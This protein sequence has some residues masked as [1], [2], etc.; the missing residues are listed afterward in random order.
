VGKCQKSQSFNFGENTRGENCAGAVEGQDR[1]EQQQKTTTPAK[2]GALV[3]E[4]VQ[5]TAQG[6]VNFWITPEMLF[7]DEETTQRP[8]KEIEML[9]LAFPK[10]PTKALYKLQ[11]SIAQEI[12]SRA[13]SDTTNLQLAQE[14]NTSLKEALSQEGKEKNMVHRQKVDEMENQVHTVFQA[15][16]DSEGV[17]GV[18]AQEKMQKIAQT[19]QHYKDQ[20]KELEEH[21]VPTTPPEIRVQRE[22]GCDSFCRKHHTEHT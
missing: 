2:E 20:I 21:A 3:G 10:I 17:Q 12:Q 13:R 6:S 16:S 19:L 14:D 4:T 18:S 11:V 22:Q 5:I 9:D 7:I 15:I 1:V 8:L